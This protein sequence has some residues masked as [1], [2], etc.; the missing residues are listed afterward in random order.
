MVVGGDF[1]DDGYAWHLLVGFDATFSF[2]GSEGCVT[3][4]SLADGGIGW[5]SVGSITP[6]S[7]TPVNLASGASY[8]FSYTARALGAY[9]VSVQAKVG[10][11]MS[12]YNPDFQN[13]DAW[14]AWPRSIFVHTFMAGTDGGDPSA[15]LSF[16]LTGLPNET[17]CFSNVS[18][19]AN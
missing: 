19:V 11:S 3:L 16:F 14:S 9:T 1:S 5:P 13:N 4:N 7:P 10:H 12:P 18:L 8:T 2:M 15:G 6:P 17:V